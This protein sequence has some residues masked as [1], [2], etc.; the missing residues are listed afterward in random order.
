MPDEIVQVGD[1]IRFSAE[2][3]E[4]VRQHAFPV[5]RVVAIRMADDGSKVLTIE[6]LRTV[7]NP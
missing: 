2:L 5:V 4:E 3:L 1:T 6:N 7:V